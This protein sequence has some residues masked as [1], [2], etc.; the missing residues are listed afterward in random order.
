[1]L[2]KECFGR[3]L[4]PSMVSIGNISVELSFVGKAQL[5]DLPGSCLQ[6]VVLLPLGLPRDWGRWTDLKMWMVESPRSW[7]SSVI[8]DNI[9]CNS[10]MVQSCRC[11]SEVECVYVLLVN[12]QAEAVLL[13]LCHEDEATVCQPVFRITRPDNESVAI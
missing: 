1:M 4:W 11:F 8:N 3:G 6:R 7:A 5:V 10:V 13:T 9:F 2:G 12:D